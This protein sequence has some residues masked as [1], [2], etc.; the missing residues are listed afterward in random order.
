MIFNFIA[1]VLIPWVAWLFRK[2]TTLERGQALLEQIVEERE[3][4]R[5]AAERI[6]DDRLKELLDRVK[7][8]DDNVMKLL[9]KDR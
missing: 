8:L 2:I 3:K 5:Q 7:H 6:R 9:T 1:V 4:S